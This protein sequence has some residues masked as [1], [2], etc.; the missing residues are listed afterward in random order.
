ETKLPRNN[1]RFRPGIST[2]RKRH[3]GA[4]T[5]LDF[6]CSERR[7]TSEAMPHDSDPGGIRLSFRVPRC[8]IKRMIKEKTNVRHTV[9]NPGFYS[10][11]F[12]PVTPPP[13]PRQFCRYDLR[14][15]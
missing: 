9:R 10:P 2:R 7:P 6:N 12:F 1:P 5:P 14:V 8:V 3:Y 4:D 15:I 11:S 13:L